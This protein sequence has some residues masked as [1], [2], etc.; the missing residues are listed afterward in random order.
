MTILDF[1][2]SSSDE[3]KSDGFSGVRNAKMKKRFAYFC[4][5]AS[6]IITRSLPSAV[7]T[8]Q[9]APEQSDSSGFERIVRLQFRFDSVQFDVQ[10]R[11]SSTTYSGSVRFYEIM[12]RFDLVP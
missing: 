4:R 5:T 7:G 1:C 6:L 12:F 11:F 8:A 3:N 2:F 9:N 10:N